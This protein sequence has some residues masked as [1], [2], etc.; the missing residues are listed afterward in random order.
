MDHSRARIVLPARRSRATVSRPAPRLPVSSWACSVPRVCQTSCTPPTRH[1]RDRAKPW[2]RT[3]HRSDR[4]HHARARTDP[5]SR[6]AQWLARHQRPARPRPRR[7]RPRSVP[8]LLRHSS[9]MLHAPETSPL[10]GSK[11]GT[12][13]EPAAQLQRCSRSAW[14]PTSGRQLGKQ[15][16]SSSPA[17][18]HFAGAYAGS[19][20]HTAGTHS[21]SVSVQLSLPRRWVRSSL[22]PDCSL[23]RMQR[24][25][26]RRRRAAR[27]DVTGASSARPAWSSYPRVSPSAG[28]SKA[29]TPRLPS[30]CYAAARP[31]PRLG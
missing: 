2:A 6:P 7:N 30:S 16:P 18:R 8:G 10:T 1:G 9:P 11:H 3:T 14:A 5:R 21:W 17:T 31:P 26:A 25:S 13:S 28:R 12:H 29:R 23:A 24:P 27:V 19:S 22:G 4:R 20:I 15:R